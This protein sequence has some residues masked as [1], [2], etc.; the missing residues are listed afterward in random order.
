MCCEEYSPRPR[1]SQIDVWPVNRVLYAANVY[2]MQ[3][4]AS[5]QCVIRLGLVEYNAKSEVEIKCCTVVTIHSQLPYLPRLCQ[6]QLTDDATNI[7]LRFPAIFPL[8]RASNI[9]DETFRPRN[10]Q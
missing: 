8:L 10:K 4:L 3:R 7:T 5:S 6:A 9:F 2:E 1:Y